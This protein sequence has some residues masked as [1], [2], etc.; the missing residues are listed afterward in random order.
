MFERTRNM[1]RRLVGRTQQSGGLTQTDDERRA[2]L[3]VPLQVDASVKQA[4]RPDSDRITAQIRNISL[5]GINLL[6]SR[7]FRP[8]ELLSVEIPA[9]ANAK[10]NDVLACVVHCA[11]ESTGEWALGCTFSRELTDDDLEAFGARRERHDAE[12]QREWKRFPSSLTATFQNAAAE[13][14]LQVPAKVLNVSASG[15]GLHTDR[16]VENG[17]L[18]S[19]ELH[20]SAGTTEKTMLACVVHV[21]QQ[22]DGTWALGCNFIRSLDEAELGELV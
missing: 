2:W 19:V 10:R 12:D 11:A 1:W 4:G 7:A 15:V 3:R 20:N 22:S 17:T 5:G 18:L 16:Y 8:G 13:D 6:G 14:A 9:G 21:T